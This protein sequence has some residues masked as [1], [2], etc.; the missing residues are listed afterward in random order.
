M[1]MDECVFAVG[2]VARKVLHVATALLYVKHA[3]K[4]YMCR[5][6]NSHG[7]VRFMY[8]E[9]WQRRD[10]GIQKEWAVLKLS[11]K[12]CCFDTL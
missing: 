5:R 7:V 10:P 3:Q 1:G 6:Y 12:T 2:N 8:N 4:G 11:A 9:H